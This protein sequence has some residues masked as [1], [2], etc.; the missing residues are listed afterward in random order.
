MLLVKRTRSVKGK[1]Q[2]TLEAARP[3]DNPSILYQPLTSNPLGFMGVGAS[4][5]LLVLLARLH[6]DAPLGMTEEAQP[7]SP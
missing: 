5:R 7:V 2:A 6:F 1:R 3:Q 4:V